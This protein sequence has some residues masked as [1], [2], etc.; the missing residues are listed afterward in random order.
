MP[1]RRRAPRRSCCSTGAATPGAAL[2]RL[3]PRRFAARPATWRSSAR[4]RS[5]LL[6]HHCGYAEPEPEACPVCGSPELSRIGAGTQK[7]ERELA[8]LFP[9]LERIR[10]DADTAARPGALAEALAR[11]AAAKSAV[12]LG[13]QMIAKGHHFPDVAL[14]A[15]V[16]ADA[17]L[18]SPTSAPR[19][20][21]SSF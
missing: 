9:E 19:S 12:L 2:P 21:P 11:F 15:V 16:D 13:T 6:C 4:G 20:A 14:A 17:G 7:L 1:S 3:R 18:P 5:P 10:L 8:R